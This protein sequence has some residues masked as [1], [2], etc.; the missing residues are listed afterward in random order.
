MAIVPITCSKCGAAVDYDDRK[1]N[2]KCHFCGTQYKNVQDVHNTII[3]H[4]THVVRTA[5][6]VGTD[7]DQ[8][9]ANME[10]LL[11]LGRFS[12]V[13][14]ILEKLLQEQAQDYRVWVGFIKF[15]LCQFDK[16]YED[17]TKV[18]TQSDLNTTRIVTHLRANR[19]K[20][21]FYHLFTD[22]ISIIE[23]E[24]RSFQNT[25]EL[26]G[27]AN[28]L[29]NNLANPERRDFTILDDNINQALGGILT[30]AKREQIGDFIICKE[31]LGH[32]LVGYSYC[33]FGDSDRIVLPNYFNDGK[34]KLNRVYIASPIKNYK[35][36]LPKEVEIIESGAFS[37]CE[38]VR[39]IVIPSTRISIY[40]NAFN[41]CMKLESIRISSKIESIQENA[42][43]GCDNMHRLVY[44]ID[45]DE[46]DVF[47]AEILN[48]IIDNPNFYGS[49][50]ILVF[51]FEW[52]KKIPRRMF[53][54]NHRITHLI[55][56]NNSNIRVSR[57]DCFIILGDGVRELE[58]QTFA[59]CEK[60]KVININVV[61][62]VIG[63]ECFSNCKHLT[64]CEIKSSN[65]TL[66]KYVF[67]GTDKKCSITVTT[68]KNRASLSREW[69]SGSKAKFNILH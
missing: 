8:I 35:I 3:N 21:T 24:H 49:E 26:I 59:S 53:F 54:N 28:E 51:Q 33:Y 50:H 57:K 40:S 4:T 25:S 45:V 47:S 5:S 10:S 46:V 64:D 52:L 34:I 67:K 17:K 58:E 68:S 56:K 48:N 62:I 31:E 66:G 6:S 1:G 13:E 16:R 44:D 15:E 43:F 65:L 69:K 61:D 20:P 12:F 2:G 11:S 27:R 39:E 14:K 55:S 60:L 22:R 18:Y 42:F 37:C 29:T 63:S 41:G 7:Y 19:K 36:V 23:H 30:F 32:S 9:I 38:E